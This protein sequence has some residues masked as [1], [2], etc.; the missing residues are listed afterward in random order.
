MPSYWK[1]MARIVDEAPTQGGLLVLPPDDF[2]QMPYTWGYVGTDS[3]VVDLFRRPVV[4]PNQQGYSPA[5]SELASAVRFTSDGILKR[6]WRQVETLVTALNAPLILVREDIDVTYP[7]RTITPP[8]QLAYALNFAPNFTLVRTVG[9]LKLFRL[10]STLH[11][12]EYVSDFITIN[13]QEPDLRL[14]SLLP[15]NAALISIKGRSGTPSA[16]QAPTIDGWQEDGN[17]FVWDPVAP[18]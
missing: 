6:D 3:F 8:S 15:N 12:S 5:S 11:E 7:G 4:L 17:T 10:T 13:T 9:P 1:E 14:L 2:Y 18:A 16:I